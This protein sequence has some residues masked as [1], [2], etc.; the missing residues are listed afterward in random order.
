M[1]TFQRTR[2][3][4]ARDLVTKVMSPRIAVIASQGATELCQA[5]YLPS[6]VDLLKP[7]GECIDSRGTNKINII[8]FFYFRQKL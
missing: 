8:Y 2:D 5:N 7:F 6:V 1:A 4:S 3:I